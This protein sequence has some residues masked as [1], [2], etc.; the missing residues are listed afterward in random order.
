MITTDIIMTYFEST[1]GSYKKSFRDISYDTENDVYLVSSVVNAFDF[2]DIVKCMCTGENVSR[3]PDGLIFKDD[4]VLFYEF[5]NSACNGT[6]QKVGL[7]LKAIE[8]LLKFYNIIK[9]IY[10]EI[11]YSCL[12]NLPIEY[13]LVY[14]NEKNPSRSKEG[15][16]RHMQHLASEEPRVRFG[17][18]RMKEYYDQ[19]ATITEF[20]SIY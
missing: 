19:V 2:D 4:R 10:P 6:K 18:E 1:Y 16:H 12:Q 20:D 8:G 15:I 3:S 9:N 7:K 14:S 13:Y 17:L 5:K 11:S